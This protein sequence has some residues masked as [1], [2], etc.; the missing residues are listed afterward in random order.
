MLPFEYINKSRCLSE[1]F[2]ECQNMAESYF[3]WSRN[4]TLDKIPLDEKAIRDDLYFNAIGWN[5]ERPPI[6]WFSKVLV[7]H[8][9][10][11]CG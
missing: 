10:L 9:F 2:T 1:L 4:I 5:S 3:R 6:S 7:H 8:F 11:N